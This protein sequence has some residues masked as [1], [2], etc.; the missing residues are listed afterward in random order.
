MLLD[1]TYSTLCQVNYISK[2]PLH[3][4]DLLKSNKWNTKIPNKMPPLIKLS[5]QWAVPVPG[6][7]LQTYLKNKMQDDSSPGTLQRSQRGVVRAYFQV[8]ERIL[9]KTEP[10]FARI[11]TPFPHIHLRVEC[12]ARQ[13]HSHKHVVASC[14]S[15][16][17]LRKGFVQTLLFR[18]LH[19]TFFFFSFF[20]V[21]VHTTTISGHNTWKLGKCGGY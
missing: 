11:F 2:Y 10:Y 12:T 8:D 20:K 5:N 13:T 6:Q 21:Y 7:S 4:K 18:T 3:D 9:F 15:A 14:I 16:L 1:L 17:Q 19:V